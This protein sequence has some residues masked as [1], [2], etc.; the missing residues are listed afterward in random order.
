MFKKLKLFFSWELNCLIYQLSLDFT[1]DAEASRI[2]NSGQ[3]ITK[4]VSMFNDDK[5]FTAHFSSVA[6]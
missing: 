5:Y 6:I 4:G 3:G 2:V 1:E